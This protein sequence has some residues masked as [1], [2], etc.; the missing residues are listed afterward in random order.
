MAYYRY[1]ENEQVT[2]SELVASLADHCQAQVSG[3][4]VLAISD[5]SEINLNAHRGRLKPEGIGVVGNNRDVGFF[6]HP[7]LVLGAEDGFPLGLS[8]VQLWTRAIGRADKKA[9]QTAKQPIETKE[10]YK[11]IASAEHS[12]RCFQ[13]GDAQL[14]THIG[15][16]EADLYEEW[17]TVP[18]AYNHLLVRIKQDRRLYQQAQSLYSYLSSQPCQGSYSIAV[19]GD[20]RSNRTSR[21][22]LLNVRFAAVEIQRPAHLEHLKETYPQ[23]L[24]LYAIEVQEVQPPQGQKPVHWRLMTTHEVRNLEQALQVISW[25]CWRWRIEQLFATLKRKG[26]NIEASQLESIAA[27]ERLTIFALSV[28]LRTLQMVEGRDNPA[29]PASVVFSQEQQLC[30]AQMAPS[31]VGKTKRQQNPHLPDTLPWATWL[32]AR[33]GG[34]SGYDSQR[35]PGMPILVRGLRQFDATFAGWKTALGGL[36]YRTHL[37]SSGL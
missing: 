33:M 2:V 3:K 36:V 12:Q 19:E 32:I 17:A 1:L 15:D 24:K 7:T 35:P 4:H 23:R 34:W 9:K 26:L 18:D 27:I 6:I 8:H 29:I 16:R 30:L 28:A 21:E 11:W 10:S 37:T 31:L 25:Y 5:T 13:I 20:A 14:V 22:A